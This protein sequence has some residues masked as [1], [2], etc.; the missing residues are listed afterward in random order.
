MFINS[1]IIRKNGE[2]VA[3][4]KYPFCARCG[5]LLYKT[6]DYLSEEKQCQYCKDYKIK[7]NGKVLFRLFSYEPNP[8]IIYMN[9][10]YDMENGALDKA[11]EKEEYEE[12]VST[13][14]LYHPTD[15][16]KKNQIREDFKQACEDFF[17]NV[18][19][20][21]P[22]FSLALRECVLEDKERHE[23][24]RVKK[25][26]EC[27]QRDEEYKKK[28]EA[29]KRYEATHPKP[30]CPTCGSA[31]V[32]KISTLNRAVSIGMVGLASDK[33]GK[34]FCCKNCGYKW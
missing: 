8:K 33:I 27:K 23:K 2:C 3:M 34:Q 12:I 16:K 11:C 19:V 22:D 20:K 30:K 7:P 17:S 9:F 31:K 14:R 24:E 4:F 32:E 25:E 10:E 15:Y 1:G 5:E 26:A 21:D 28:R 18:V 6:G 29:E 13:H